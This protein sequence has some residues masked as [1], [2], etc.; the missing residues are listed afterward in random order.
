MEGGDTMMGTQ[1]VNIN[2]ANG[3]KVVADEDFRKPIK[4]QDGDSVTFTAT[5]TRAIVIIPNAMDIFGLTAPGDC[6]IGVIEAGGSWT[7]PVIPDLSAGRSMTKSRPANDANQGEYPYTVYCDE[8][9]QFAYGSCPV[10]LIE[11]P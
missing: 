8:S 6:L 7:T 1:T 11:P 3:E 5:G 4:R 2:P 9:E 10:L